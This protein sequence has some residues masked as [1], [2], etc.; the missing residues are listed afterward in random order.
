MSGAFLLWDALLKSVS[1]LTPRFLPVLVQRLVESLV[2]A[3]ERDVANDPVREAEYLWAR[4]LVLDESWAEE[5]GRAEQRVREEVLETCILYQNVWGRL[6]SHGIVE[7][8][9]EA[10]KERWGDTIEAAFSGNG[11]SDLADLEGGD[12]PADA[13]GDAEMREW[14]SRC[15][16]SVVR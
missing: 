15:H 10:F 16:K 14:V 13:E 4:R 6:L 7:S 2:A 5:R 3:S 1:L 8:E 11:G 12:N 9:S